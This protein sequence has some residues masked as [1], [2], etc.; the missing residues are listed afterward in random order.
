[1]SDEQNDENKQESQETQEKTNPVQE[2]KDI[3][4]ETKRATAEMKEER[5]RL[6]RAKADAILSGKAEAGTKAPEP[7][8]ETAKEYAERVMRGEFNQ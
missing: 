5:Q 2:A 1:M 7:K 8:E 3:L 4:A 6:E